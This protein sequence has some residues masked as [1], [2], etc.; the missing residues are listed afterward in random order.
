MFNSFSS[1]VD[2][3]HLEVKEP[4]RKL[5]LNRKTMLFDDTTV[6]NEIA[7]TLFYFP[8]Y[9]VKCTYPLDRKGYMTGFNTVEKL[10]V[11]SIQILQ[12]PLDIHKV[13]Y[14]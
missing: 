14:V 11:D 1:Y 5:R 7:T 13:E 6:A 8:W 12:D 2:E 10:T 3:I 9:V 4:Y